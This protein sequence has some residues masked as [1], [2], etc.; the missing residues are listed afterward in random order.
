MLFF[1]LSFPLALLLT[2]LMVV[3]ANKTGFVDRP[4]PP[5]KRHKAPVPYLGGIALVFAVALPLAIL[6]GQLSL[7]REWLGLGLG[8]LLIASGGLLDDRRTLPVSAKL[9][10]QLA[11]CACAWSFGLRA[12]V[13]GAPLPD[14]ALTVLWIVGVCNAWN[15][16][17]IMDGLAT[18]VCA[19]TAPFLALLL[20]AKG[21][22]AYG[23]LLLG[24]TG[25]CLGFL[26]YNV[27]PARIYLGDAGSQW[28]GYL[29]ACSA[30][31][32][33]MDEPAGLPLAIPV[34]VLGVPLFETVFVSWLRLKKG[35]SPFRGSPDHYALRL[36][37]LGI[38]IP[39]IVGQSIAV[40][41][42]L[43]GTGVFLAFHRQAAGL[44]LAVS[45]LA[46]LLAGRRL[47]RIDMASLPQG[48]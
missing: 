25:A 24:L 21:D 42:A 9:A 45:L 41:V 37:R 31:K 39:A 38:P 34:L 44:I 18:G 13:F 40:T 30:L 3:L 43:G 8:G 16:I 6:S 12:Q 4:I 23:A 7:S 19:G 10:V 32:W 46:A 15:L 5:L 47:G 27:Q 17:D 29:T 11:A 2:P 22:A 33:T 28:I 35:H 36:R 26:P 14:A 20:L 1:A 48:G